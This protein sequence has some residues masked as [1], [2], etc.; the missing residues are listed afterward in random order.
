MGW[1]PFAFSFLLGRSKLK[2]YGFKV[3]GLG[4][5]VKGLGFGVEDIAFQQIGVTGSKG[6]YTHYAR[7]ARPSTLNLND[8]PELKSS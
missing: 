8:K 5:R 4:F 6:V 1:R 2:R 3:Q 7:N